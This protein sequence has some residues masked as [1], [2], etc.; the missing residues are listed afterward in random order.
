MSSSLGG[1]QFGGLE[2][3]DGRHVGLLVQV[4]YLQE[5]E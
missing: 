1:V 2:L 4:F 3:L 5:E